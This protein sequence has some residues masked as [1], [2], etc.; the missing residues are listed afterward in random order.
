MSRIL[1]AALALLVAGPVCFGQTNS[2]AAPAQSL[3]RP[4]LKSPAKP[5]Q[6]SPAISVQANAHSSIGESFVAHSGNRAEASRP[7]GRASGWWED[8]ANAYPVEASRPLERAGDGAPQADVSSQMSLEGD[9]A[10]NTLFQRIEREGL[11]QTRQSIRKSR[12]NRDLESKMD[13]SSHHPESFIWDS[14]VNAARAL[15]TCPGVP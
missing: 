7:P 8:A 13:A 15:G 10:K 11:L 3:P 1:L 6:T 14:P 5:E 4:A 2:S 9:A 12:Y